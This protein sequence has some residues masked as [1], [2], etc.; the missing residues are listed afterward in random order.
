MHGA[1]VSDVR[2]G[3]ADIGITYIEDIT[4]EFE[5]LEL[6]KEAFHVVMPRGHSLA[7][8]ESVAL[9]DLRDAALV[10]LPKEAQTRRVLDGI[11]LAEGIT[12]Q[13]AVTVH[14]FATIMQFVHAGV[15]LAVVPAGAIPTASSAGLA[16]R[17]LK[18]PS[19]VRSMGVI[20]LKDRSLTPSA[21][22]FLA[23]L[24]SFWAPHK[25][26]E[27]ALAPTAKRSRRTR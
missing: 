26:E 5:S 19:I 9:E 10:S 3:V 4:P 12:L 16:S 18:K 23:H 2:S 1:V 6:S 25:V 13:H 17:P 8:R 22:G 27:A 21:S 14:Q 7:S 15:G 20:R 11:A 24:K